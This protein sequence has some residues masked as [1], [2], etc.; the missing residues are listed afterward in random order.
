MDQ[1]HGPR[2]P[3]GKGQYPVSGEGENARLVPNTLG[4]R[5]VADELRVA[6]TEQELAEQLTHAD[7]RGQPVTLIGDGSNLVLRPRLP[8]LAVLLRMR[9]ITF[10]RLGTRTWRVAASAGETWHDLVRAALGRG[11]PGVEN[12]ALI[13]GTVGAAPVQNIGAYGRELREV[14]EAV[15]VFDPRRGA[16]FTLPVDECGL[17]YRDSR[18]RSGDRHL[19]IVRV[20]LLLGNAPLRFD[21]PDLRRELT[22]MGLAPERVNAQE[23]AEAVVRV[24]R[25]KLPDP[26]RIGNVGSFFKN[27]VVSTA[28]LDS[29]RARIPIDAFPA[30]DATE[31]WK[32]SAARLIDA[33]GWKGVRQGAMQVWQRQPLVLVNRGGANGNDA[34]RLAAAIQSD[35]HD[36]YGV[37]LQLE[38]K[39]AGV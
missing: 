38:P 33:A 34:L 31:R 36:K 23:V 17:R 2:A 19:A 29:I 7:R 24:R 26:Q 12:L 21:Y 16:F 30:P 18:F 15:T 39:V 4:V 8:G 14:L 20:A 27:P 28:Q 37:A 13:P 9:G 11:I 6:R 22:R 5:C 10:E 1:R 3:S 35:V 25:R 32:I